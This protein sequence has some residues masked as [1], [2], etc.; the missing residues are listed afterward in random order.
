MRD[1]R[2][3]VIQMSNFILADAVKEGLQ[4]GSDYVV[5][6]TEEASSL[7][8][9]CLRIHPHVVLM[10]VTEFP[11][12][13]LSR[14]LQAR[15]EILAGAPECKFVILCDEKASPVLAERVKQAKKDKQIDCFLYVSV[16]I[17][18]LVALMDT[19]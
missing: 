8:K 7:T 1:L 15:D 10:E 18:Y 12:Y 14:R 4:N 17:S 2:R 11:P 6:L 13:T 9:D 5:H 19:L 16:S 3:A